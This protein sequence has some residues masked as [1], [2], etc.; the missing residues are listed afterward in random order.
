MRIRVWF[1]ALLSGLGIWHHCELWCR[2]QMRLRSRIAVAVAWA[3]SYSFDLT[4]RLGTS[5]CGA[6][7]KRQKTNK[8]KPERKKT[9]AEIH[10]YNIYFNVKYKLSSMVGGV[11]HY[12]RRSSQE[13]LQSTRENSFFKLKLGYFKITCKTVTN[14]WAKTIG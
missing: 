2:L 4:Q 1:L 9:A 6:A 5:I 3:G 13:A 11:R 8:Q 14:Q 10:E 12:F 7:L